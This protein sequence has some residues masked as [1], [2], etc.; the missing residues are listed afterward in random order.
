MDA[1]NTKK[2]E[3]TNANNSNNPNPNREI[4]PQNKVQENKQERKKEV[5]PN[6]A[7]K[8]NNSQNNNNNNNNTGNKEKRR[9]NNRN[10]R[11]NRNSG[12]KGVNGERVENKEQTENLEKL[13]KSEKL[14]KTEKGV[15]GE[16]KADM[17]VRP[18]KRPKQQN[19]DNRDNRENREK[20]A[21]R[22]KITPEDEKNINAANNAETK[23]DKADNFGDL[24]DVTP[25]RE[26]TAEAVAEIEDGE[27]VEIVGVRYKPV[28][29]IYFFDP[30]ETKYE[31]NDKVI[32]EPS[33]GVELGYVVIKNRMVSSSKIVPPLKPVLRRATEDDVVKV[34]N[35]KALAKQAMTIAEERVKAHGLKLKLIEAEY[36]FDNS[37]LMY[38]FTAENRID[39]RELVKDLASIFKVRIELRQIGIRDQT[40]IVGGLSICGRPFCCN[41]FLQ[42]FEQVT[43]KMAKE[44]N[45]SI[46]SAKISGA[47]GRL[48]CCLRYEHE[49]YESLCKE[50]PKLNTIVETPTGE[51]GVIIEANVLSGICKV[52]INNKNKSDQVNVIKPYSKDELKQIGFVKGGEVHNNKGDDTKK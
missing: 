35:N 16:K 47:C 3:K 42:N 32:V 4:K 1:Q 17:R 34:Q 43:I 12:E 24:G 15:Q 2:P 6:N 26:N 39:F 44:Q 23:T 31:V 46:N 10:R 41:S 9:F 40:K 30:G 11:R 21:E 18:P 27:D 25:V 51:T 36:T 14:E 19:R 33:R 29:K 20:F 13:D 37:K 38:F 22:S 45:I 50:T 8:P 28:G 5:S 7:D 48:M 49:T 52:R